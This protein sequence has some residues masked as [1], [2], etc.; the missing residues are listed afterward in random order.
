VACGSFSP[1]GY[2]AYYSDD[3]GGTWTGITAGGS[4]FSDAT[5]AYSCGGHLWALL[6]GSAIY[7]SRDNATTFSATSM[8]G[9]FNTDFYYLMGDGRKLLAVGEIG[10]NAAS[11]AYADFR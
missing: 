6:K 1:A 5:E 9:F 8:P 10:T 11:L 2:S 3:D 4:G 7:I